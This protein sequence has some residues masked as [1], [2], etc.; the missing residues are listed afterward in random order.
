MLTEILRYSGKGI[1]KGNFS[2][3]ISFTNTQQLRD[4]MSF[5]NNDNRF[6]N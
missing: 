4:V 3:E 6:I 2:Y 5:P 1:P